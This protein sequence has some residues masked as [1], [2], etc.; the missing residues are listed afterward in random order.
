[1]AEIAPQPLG[2]PQCVGTTASDVGDDPFGVVKRRAGKSLVDEPLVRSH[3]DLLLTDLFLEARVP[4][5]TPRLVLA[6]ESD[7]GEQLPESN[8]WRQLADF[9]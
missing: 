7:V 2:Q 4:K 5:L 6:K 8:I 3:V 9:R 1:M